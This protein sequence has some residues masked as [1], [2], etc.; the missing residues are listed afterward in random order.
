MPS[1]HPLLWSIWQETPQ[2]VKLYLLFLLAVS[3]YI[4]L[5][6]V[7]TMIRLR[8][9]KNP[10]KIEDVSSVQGSLKVLEAKS[11][12][13]RQTLG[14]AFYLF[15]LIFCWSFPFAIRT[16][17]GYRSFL[18]P[19]LHDFFLYFALAQRA[20]FIFVILHS[21]QW[22]VSRQTH[23]SSQRLNARTSKKVEV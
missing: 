16:E 13:A 21:A 5:S 3:F 14:A 23:K 17:N 7:S 22:F 11:E 9:L 20:F 8:A 15:G 6:S 19:A 10:S 2:L 4:L 18:T 1:P 12:N